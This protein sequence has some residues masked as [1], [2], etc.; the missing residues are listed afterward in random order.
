MILTVATI[1]GCL[2]L[3]LF[4][5][6]AYILAHSATHIAAHVAANGI[7]LH[8]HYRIVPGGA[9]S[10]AGNI[11]ICGDWTMHA[12]WSWTWRVWWCS[13]V[14]KEGRFRRLLT[15][16]TT[17]TSATTITSATTNGYDRDE[18]QQDAWCHP[19]DD[20]QVERSPTRGEHRQTKQFN[21][22]TLISILLVLT[23]R[24]ATVNSMRYQEKVHHFFRDAFSG[25]GVTCMTMRVDYIFKIAQSY[26]VGES[27]VFSQ[28][29]YC[30]IHAWTHDGITQVSWQLANW[31]RALSRSLR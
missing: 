12:W 11:C 27:N 8:L 24:T 5:T 13:I 3:T 17:P 6:R 18:Q 7:R 22:N 26:C 21:A 2:G 20:K 25:L 1:E 4:S 28:M 23:S 14:G 31:K 10:I 9:I 29:P 19:H 30:R 16:N 15:I